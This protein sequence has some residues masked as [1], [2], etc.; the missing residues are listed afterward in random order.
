MLKIKGTT[1]HINRGDIG[2]IDVG[3]VR[4][5]E[6]YTFTSGDVVRF[7][8]MAAKACNNVILQK[9]VNVTEDTEVITFTLS[10]ADTTIGGVISKPVVYWYEVE[11][12]PETAPETII[13]YDDYGAKEFIL[14][15]EGV[16]VP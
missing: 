7:Q 2:V 11:L 5:G 1:I 3:A 12:N 6:T 9:V 4:D 15:P 14:Y 13:G 8:I 10:A 16:K